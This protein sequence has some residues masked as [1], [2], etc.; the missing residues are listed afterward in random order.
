MLG[1]EAGLVVHAQEANHPIFKSH[2]VGLY[3]H[4][5]AQRRLAGRD[6][7]ELCSASA[8][9][10]CPFASIDKQLPVMLEF[11]NLPALH[12]VRSWHDLENKNIPHVGDVLYSVFSVVLGIAVQLA[13]YQGKHRKW[14]EPSKWHDKNKPHSL[15]RKEASKNARADVAISMR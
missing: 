3:L 9:P 1:W 7:T 8:H 2:F 12:C 13:G 10:L 6:C 15:V 5:G 11:L 4:A 14:G